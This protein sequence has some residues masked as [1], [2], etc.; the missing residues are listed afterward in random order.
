MED[1]RLRANGEYEIKIFQIDTTH[2]DLKG[3]S[4][5]KIVNTLVKHH[6]TRIVAT[7]TIHDEIIPKLIDGVHYY[8]YV[9]N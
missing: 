4:K 6:K 5:H 1:I 9:Y 3:L 7:E 2:R 8:T